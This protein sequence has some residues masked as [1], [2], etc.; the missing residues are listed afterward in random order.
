MWS[1]SSINE[2]DFNESGG[3]FFVTDSFLVGECSLDSLASTML[4]RQ[5]FEVRIIK[6]NEKFLNGFACKV[7]STSYFTWLNGAF[8]IFN[9]I[10]D[11]LE[12]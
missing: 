6:R 1:E 2:G 4:N 7:C 8:F 12:L 9:F 11:S 10:I 3:G 5:Q